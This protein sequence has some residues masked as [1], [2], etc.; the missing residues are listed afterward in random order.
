MFLFIFL[1][2]KA[3]YYYR[4]GE[5]GRFSMRGCSILGPKNVAASV[6]SAKNI[7]IRPPFKV[8]GS[9]RPSTVSFIHNSFF[10]FNICP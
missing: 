9:N 10:K 7:S 8:G 2:C 5:G 1:H 6:A 3:Y 4:R